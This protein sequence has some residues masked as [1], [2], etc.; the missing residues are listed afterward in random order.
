MAVACVQGG[1]CRNPPALSCVDHSGQAPACVYF[2]DEPPRRRRRWPKTAP[3]TT[4]KA[5]PLAAAPIA[6][7]TI[8]TVSKPLKAGI[9]SWRICAPITPPTAP[10]TAFRAGSKRP[11][12]KSPTTKP[13]VIPAI[14][15]MMREIVSGTIQFPRPTFA[16]TPSNVS[17]SCGP[18]G[19]PGRAAL[20]GSGI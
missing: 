5:T 18:S 9:T 2:E 20:Q 17:N 6:W 4:V 13:P 10:T 16:S 15:Q 7:P 1:L 8:E 12:R 11:L 19:Q 3:A 14:S